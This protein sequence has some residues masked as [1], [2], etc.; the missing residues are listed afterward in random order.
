MHDLDLIFAPIARITAPGGVIAFCEP[1]AFN[2]LYYIQIAITPH[3]TWQ[4]DKGI[5]NMR[6]SKVL[7]AMKRA[8]LIDVRSVGFGFFPPFITNTRIGQR[9]EDVLEAARIFGW[10]H[11]F[12]IFL[13]KKPG[14]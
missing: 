6:P 13:G 9:V 2:P 5:V 10:L 3:M 12:Q 14:F 7:P 11:A 8:G 4:G 1:V